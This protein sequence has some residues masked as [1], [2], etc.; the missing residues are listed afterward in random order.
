VK[1]RGWYGLAFG[2][3]LIGDIVRTVGMSGARNVIESGF[4]ASLRSLGQAPG[5]GL[6]SPTCLSRHFEVVRTSVPDY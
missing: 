6:A 5:F 3:V 2:A 1:S 4:E